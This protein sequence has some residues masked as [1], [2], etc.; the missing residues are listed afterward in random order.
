M[1]T[2]EIDDLW[3]ETLLGLDPEGRMRFRS[4]VGKLMNDAIPRC[5]TANNFHEA[6][7]ALWTKSVLEAVAISKAW[8][9]EQ[10]RRAILAKMDA[11]EDEYNDALAAQDAMND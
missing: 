9:P 1:A 8:I 10:E 7:D 5:S 4:L 11:M 3:T 2:P 6:F